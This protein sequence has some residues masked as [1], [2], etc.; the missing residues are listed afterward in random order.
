MT[1]SIVENSPWISYLFKT[2]SLG[3]IFESDIGTTFPQTAISE[4]SE[5]PKFFVYPIP[6]SSMIN[7]VCASKGII[8]YRLVDISG[9]IVHSGQLQGTSEIDVSDYPN[10]IY[11]LQLREEGILET[12]KIII[13]H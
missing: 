12:R 11:F 7:R 2:D 5:N 4:I 10:G 13:S 9:K 3:N 6:A 8:S 1:G